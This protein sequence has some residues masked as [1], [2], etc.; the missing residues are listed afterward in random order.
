MGLEAW[1]GVHNG[2]GLGMAYTGVLGAYFEF[3][4]VDSL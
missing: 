1:N 2:A 3:F 4:A